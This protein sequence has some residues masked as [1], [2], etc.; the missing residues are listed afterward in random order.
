MNRSNTSHQVS[1]SP[2]SR[3]DDIPEILPLVESET[4]FL[5]KRRSIIVIA[6][7]TGVNFLSS[8][9]NGLLIVGLPR[10]ALDVNL[11]THLLLW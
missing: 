1:L 3:V 9:S 7:L 2:P 8:L 4:G 10:M 5:P 11:P 6:T